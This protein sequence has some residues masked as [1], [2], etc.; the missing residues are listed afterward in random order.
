ME[1]VPYVC[2]CLQKMPFAVIK[3]SVHYYPRLRVPGHS[4]S[5][6]NSVLIR[7]CSAAAEG[8]FSGTSVSV[9]VDLIHTEHEKMLSRA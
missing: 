5:A 8:T 3:S 9:P 7:S 6:R 4:A 1:R 2:D